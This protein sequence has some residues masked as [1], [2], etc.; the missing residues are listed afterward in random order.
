MNFGAAA[1]LFG[2]NRITCSLLFQFLPPHSA[3][4]EVG[5]LQLQQLFIESPTFDNPL[6]YIVL[7]LSEFSTGYSTLL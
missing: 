7:M 5:K 6:F 3:S 4:S 2:V 1:K